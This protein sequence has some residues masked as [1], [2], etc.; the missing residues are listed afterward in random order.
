LPSNAK[1]L[2]A[3]EEEVQRK[4]EIIMIINE[5]MRKFKFLAHL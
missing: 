1:V 3:L 5:N 2:I 4:I